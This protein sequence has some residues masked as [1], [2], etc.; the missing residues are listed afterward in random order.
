M[1]YISAPVFEARA[2]IT[3]IDKATNSADSGTSLSINKPTGGGGIQNGDVL[4]RSEGLNKGAVA[5]VIVDGGSGS[6]GGADALS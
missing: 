6:G 2:A 1:I 3:V 5:A 4:M